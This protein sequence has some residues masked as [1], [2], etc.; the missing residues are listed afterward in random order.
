MQSSEIKLQTR[1]YQTEQSIGF[2]PS[3]VYAICLSRPYRLNTPQLEHA[4]QVQ[5]V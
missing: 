1:E 4:I 3:R 2:F 5:E